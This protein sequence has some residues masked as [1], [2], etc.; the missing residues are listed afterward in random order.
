MNEDLV[1]VVVGVLFYLLTLGV[2]WAL[3]MTRAIYPRFV[4]AVESLAPVSAILF[5][6]LIVM[7]GMPSVWGVLLSLAIVAVSAWF[8][9]SSRVPF[10]FRAWSYHRLT[11]DA[12]YTITNP[13][14]T[15]WKRPRF[16]ASW[17]PE[18]L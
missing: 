8:A 14:P 9:W 17:W 6:L 2:F 13:P 5:A 3:T 16:I 12:Y 7:F 4:G 10:V 11:G 1:T 18:W 15:V